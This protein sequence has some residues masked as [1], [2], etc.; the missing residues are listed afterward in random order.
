MLIIELFP[1]PAGP[2]IPITIDLPEFL[3][4][5]FIRGRAPLGSFSINDIAFAIAPR[6]PFFS[7]VVNL[8]VEL[9][10]LQSAENYW[11]SGFV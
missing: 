5:F 10:D 6:F 7:S 8:A 1:A 9:T 11:R 3:K 4:I 2:V